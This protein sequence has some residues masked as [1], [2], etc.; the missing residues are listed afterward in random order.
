MP[1]RTLRSAVLDSARRLEITRP[2]AASETLGL[3]RPCAPET[4]ARQGDLPERRHNPE[5]GTIG[6]TERFRQLTSS[7]S[8]AQVPAGR[9]K[10]GRGIDCLAFTIQPRGVPSM[11]CAAQCRGRCRSRA[12][13]RAGRSRRRFR[14]FR[15][16]NRRRRPSACRGSQRTGPW[17]GGCRLKRAKGTPA[18]G[19]DHVA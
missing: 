9:A 5:V 3:C 12:A 4:P 15:P 2:H 7:S 13:N 1:C 19:P 14:A 16:P 8:G 18:I 11:D 6:D 10:L 17:R